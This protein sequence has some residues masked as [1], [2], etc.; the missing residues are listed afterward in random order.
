MTQQEELNRR[1]RAALEEAVAPATV[2]EFEE[3]RRASHAYEQAL[4]GMTEAWLTYRVARTP[5]ATD[6]V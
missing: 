1:L 2:E 3:F 5:E 4:N 6:G